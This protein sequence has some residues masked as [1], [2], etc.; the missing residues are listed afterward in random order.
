M[1][2]KKKAKLIFTRVFLVSIFLSIFK[3]K[4]ILEIHNETSGITKFFFN[5]YYF[6]NNKKFI[7]II[8]IHKNLKNTFLY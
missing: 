7:K 1:K 3:I 4:H 5:Y 2:V 8:Y 6:F